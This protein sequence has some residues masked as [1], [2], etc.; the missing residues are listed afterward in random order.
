MIHHLTLIE[1]KCN[2]NNIER[3]LLFLEA[4][5]CVRIEQIIIMLSLHAVRVSHWL[6]IY[7]DFIRLESNTQSSDAAL[8]T[9]SVKTDI[10]RS[11]TSFSES[12]ISRSISD[13]LTA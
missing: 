3:L 2:S 13:L 7:N 10:F 4:Q 5:L 11:I 12:N 8:D 6:L 9:H 1:Y